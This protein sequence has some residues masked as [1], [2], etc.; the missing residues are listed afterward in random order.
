MHSQRCFRKLRAYHSCS[1]NMTPQN[2]HFSLQSL[3]W[4]F[5]TYDTNGVMDW[6][7][8][9]LHNSYVEILTSKVMALG[10][11][12]LEVVR[13]WAES[14]HECDW[15]P[16][17]KEACFLCFPLSL[18]LPTIWGYTEK[19]AIFKPWTGLTRYHL[20]WPAPWT[21]RSRFQELWEMNVGGLSRP[22]YGNCYNS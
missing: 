7:F 9:F 11:R 13:S 15:C 19:T 20:D 5:S 17:K 4:I 22:V 3:I 10:G 1:L 21:W 14:P 8:V 6:M 2:L 18:L 12:A 16:Y